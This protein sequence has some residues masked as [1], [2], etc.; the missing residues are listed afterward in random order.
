MLDIQTVYTRDVA[1]LKGVDFL[2]TIR[3]YDFYWASKVTKIEID[4]IETS[5][6][7][8]GPFSLFVSLPPNGLTAQGLSDA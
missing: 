3:L 4:G 2:T 5:F 7:S 6:S 8:I 1:N